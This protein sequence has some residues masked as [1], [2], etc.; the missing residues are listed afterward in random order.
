MVFVGA[1][2]GMRRLQMQRAVGTSRRMKVVEVLRLSPKSTVF[3]VEVDDRNVLIG[4]TGSALTLLGE[5]PRP[6]HAQR[7]CETARLS[8]RNCHGLAAPSRPPSRRSHTRRAVDVR[9][10]AGRRG[11]RETTGVDI[12]LN[13]GEQSG[14]RWLAR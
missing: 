9:H 12:T 13:G 3:L 6:N 1:M 8:A 10:A 11:R 2:Y 7:Q 5:H 4:Q 14:T